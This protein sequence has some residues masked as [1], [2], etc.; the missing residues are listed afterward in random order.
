TFTIVFWMNVIQLPLGLAGSH[1][2]HYGTLNGRELA[3]AA[4]LAVV[5]AASHYCL[6]NAF[7][8]GDAILVV[9]LDFLRIP[10]I[11][12]VGFALYGEP[13]DGVVFA[14]ASLIVG[15]VLWN[16]ISEARRVPAATRGGSPPA[17]K[18][19]A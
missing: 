15:G 8:Y 7:R 10:L 11:A 19:P 2:A 9:P 3:A 5:G 4:G 13:L 6:S 17:S 16:L 18:A 14:G 12:L 1:P